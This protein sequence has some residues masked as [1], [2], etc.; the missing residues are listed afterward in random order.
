MRIVPEQLEM[1]FPPS[2]GGRRRGAGRKPR[3][4]RR[5]MP[6]APRPLHCGRHPVHVT[7]RSAF[8]PLRSQFVFPT[9]RAAIAKTRVRRRGTFRIVHFSVQH[10]HI[11]LIVEANDTAALIAGVRGLEVSIAKRVNRLTFRRGSFW[12]DRWHGRAL[13]TPR[14][15]RH[16]IVYVLSN[17]KKHANHPGIGVLDPYS[18]APYF[19][20][21]AE[22][23]G[24]PPIVR[25]AR[26][27]PRSLAPPAGSPVSEPS[28][29]LLG[30]GWRRHGLI[31]IHE[32]PAGR[33][34][35]RSERG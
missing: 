31:A 20:G 15:V 8:R 1:P 3:T 29:W 35:S 2:W 27:V 28:T 12:A 25:N 19:S 4:G 21:Y 17:G 30:V 7:L 24:L 5:Q 18:S 26:I 33:N 14:A 13:T 11:H 10:D 22:S 6:H 16:A 34:R 32:A 23:T 9:V